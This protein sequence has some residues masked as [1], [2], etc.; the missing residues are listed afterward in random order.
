MNYVKPLKVFWLF[1]IQQ[2]SMIDTV[3]K[4][5]YF[6]SVQTSGWLVPLVCVKYRLFVEILFIINW[7]W[8]VAMICEGSPTSCE[9]I[10]KKFQFVFV[11]NSVQNGRNILKIDGTNIIDHQPRSSRLLNPEC[12]EKPA[13]WHG[14]SKF[15]FQNLI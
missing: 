7:C 9:F 12:A 15:W 14:R 11:L 6:I 3:H 1:D 4:L 13:G 10:L 2:D 8:N 5:L